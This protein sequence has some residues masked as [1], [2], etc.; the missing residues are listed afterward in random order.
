MSRDRNSNHSMALQ[1]P[2]NSDPSNYHYKLI[3]L[4]AKTANN[5]IKNSIRNYVLEKFNE[6]SRN[7]SKFWDTVSTLIPDI[8]SAKIDGVFSKDNSFITER[9]AANEINSYFV[10]VGTELNKKLPDCNSNVCQL[11]ETVPFVIDQMNEISI[12]SVEIKLERI[13]VNK[14]SG[15]AKINS[16]LLTIALLSQ[17]E[18]FCK[19]LNL[20][21]S[22]CIFPF[23]WKTN[24]VILIPKKGDT[25]IVSN[26]RPVV[27]LPI[28]GKILEKCL[29][30]HL[31]HYLDKHNIL[32]DSQGRLH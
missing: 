3:L 30:I 17:K 10:N 25:R 22:T 27:L 18:R 4:S 13:D 28:P 26:L 20:C 11:F 32:S 14:S 6:S 24:M 7:P 16:R 19:L 23:L 2:R 1:V 8:K 29:G 5:D 9:E 31:S 12:Q 21:I 15:I